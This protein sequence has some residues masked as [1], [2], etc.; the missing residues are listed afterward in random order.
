MRSMRR[1]GWRILLVVFGVFGALTTQSAQAQKRLALVVGIDKYEAVTPLRRAVSDARAMA[2]KLNNLNFDVTEVY[3]PT[4]R[5][6]NQAIAVFSSRISSGDV[7]TFFFAGHG[8]EIKGQNFLLPKDVPQVNAAQQSLLRSEG[9]GFN[10]VLSDVQANGPRISIIILDAC[11]DNPFAASSGTRGALGTRGLARVDPPSGAFVIYSAASRQKALDRLSNSDRNPNSVFTRKLLPLLD[12]PGLDVRDMV[13]K[14]R[15]DVWN[16][17]QTVGHEQFPAY[18]DQIRGN[19][20]FKQTSG[21]QCGSTKTVKTAPVPQGQLV[22]PQDRSAW[23]ETIACLTRSNDDRNKNQCFE[24]YLRNFPTGAFAI[25]A[26]ESLVQLTNADASD[27]S[28]DETSDANTGRTLAQYDGTYKGTRGY[29]RRG[30]PSPHKECKSR[31]SMTVDVSG[32]EI[33]FYSDG[34]RFRGSVSPS[35]LINI[36]GR[37]VRPRPRTEFEI[38]GTLEDASMY[39]GYCGVGYFRLRKTGDSMPRDEQDRDSKP[40]PRQSWN[41]TYNVTRGYTG[42]IPKSKRRHCKRRYTLTAWVENGWI[43]YNSDG[44]SWRGRVDDSGMISIN[45]RDARPRTKSRFSI[46][47]HISDARMYSAFCGS[48]YFRAVKR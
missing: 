9:V 25:D 36:K 2:A 16:L 37:D 40:A 44:R 18:Y 3:D 31:Y 34:R 30:R 12:Q 21:A 17:A 14:L 1:V 28:L 7:V 45:G 26:Q 11:R 43:T 35:G 41:G 29:T 42:R 8:V 38:S 48:G 10:R 4:R 19:F 5:E 33:S 13:H 27:S 24:E 46:S 22:S 15:N 6:L 20:C 32:G 39:S 23:N 47:G